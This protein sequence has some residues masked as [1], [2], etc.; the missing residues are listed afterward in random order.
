MEIEWKYLAA[1]VAATLQDAA[2]LS[3]GCN[4]KSAEKDDALVYEA[5]KRISMAGHYMNACYPRWLIQ[6]KGFLESIVSL[7]EFGAWLLSYGHDLPDGY[8][9]LATQETKVSDEAE[10]VHSVAPEQAATTAP[11]VPAKP[12]QA[13]RFQEQEILRV[14]RELGFDAK[15]LP[16]DEQGKDG[17]KAK[18]RAITP[19]Q[20][21]L[22]F[23]KAWGRLSASK[24]IIKLK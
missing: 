21:P 8:P 1:G 18:V 22:I 6:Q 23:D 16:K 5:S 3:V 11:V 7:P 4:P 14:I 20:T 12:L 2:L 19:F 17:V 10:N 13:H 24:E 15:A 9:R